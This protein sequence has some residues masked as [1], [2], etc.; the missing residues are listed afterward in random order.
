[1]KVSKKLGAKQVVMESLLDRRVSTCLLCLLCLRGGG[2]KDHVG[3][4]HLSD[5]E[6]HDGD[7]TIGSERLLSY[8]TKRQ[9][10]QPAMS[11]IYAI[12]IYMCYGYDLHVGLLLP[13]SLQSSSLSSLRSCSVGVPPS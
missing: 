6:P 2:S 7:L 3:N 10:E 9:N 13:H 8:Q 11:R 5:I 1:M 4:R 12:Y